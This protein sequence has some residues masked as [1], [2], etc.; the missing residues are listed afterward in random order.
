MA[1]KEL[2]DAELTELQTKKRQERIDRCT[3]RIAEL[4]EEENCTLDVSVELTMRGVSPK[5][6]VIPKG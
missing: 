6:T 2:S 4:L 1:D 5:I 3:Q